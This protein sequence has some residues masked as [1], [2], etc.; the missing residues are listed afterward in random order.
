MG[1]NKTDLNLVLA[2]VLMQKSR[3]EGKPYD[4]SFKNRDIKNIDFYFQD[5]LSS[6]GN[7]K[8]TYLFFAKDKNEADI[9]IKKTQ[10]SSAY[11]KNNYY[12]IV[13][14]QKIKAYTVSNFFVVGK[15]FFKEDLDNYT[16]LNYG[17]LSRI[18]KKTNTS[19]NNNNDISDN[20]TDTY[21]KKTSQQTPELFSD[22]NA[23]D[24]RALL[25]KDP[26]NCAFILGNGVSIP[27]GSDSW[28]KLVDNLVDYLTPFY[29][30]N[31]SGISNALSD[32]MYLLSSF[33]ESTFS[34]KK[35]EDVYKSG[36]GY[37]I[38]R[39]YNAG[40]LKRNSLLKAIALA[41]IRFPKLAVLTYNY[42]DF[43][44]QQIKYCGGEI[45]IYSGTDFSNKFDSSII[46]LHGTI[47][48]TTRGGYKINQL[49]LT[50][51][52]YYE[53]YL[54]NQDSWVF[55]AQH[56]VLSNKKVLFIGSSMSDLF[57]LS[58]INDVASEKNRD[59]WN[60]YAL[61]CFK[62]LNN[63]AIGELNAFYNKKRVKIIY[64]D[65]FEKLAD[66]LNEITG[67]SFDEVNS[68]TPGIKETFKE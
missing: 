5:G 4:F 29:I 36:L 45:K 24:F 38:Y 37:C 51:Q 32:S 59:D 23:N 68:G 27:F 22:N 18:F 44:E 39:K 49:V 35:L 30:D 20:S 13:C 3:L 63:D 9:L 10:S 1:N 47:R 48:K 64:V 8:S 7:K 67:L 65:G 41:K 40:M 54:K 61:L 34:D 16:K 31:R 26:S 2:D 42:D 21:E 25:K 50:D 52:Q 46:H 28:K 53:T 15:D 14:G 19:Q 17:F 62:G 43:L 66:K 57:Q 6:F 33:V 11:S 55:K 60:C 56:E 58:L 12:V